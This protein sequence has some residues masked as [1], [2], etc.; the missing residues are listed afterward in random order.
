MLTTDYSSVICDMAAVGL[1]W[2]RAFGLYDGDN[3][4]GEWDD[5]KRRWI[6]VENAGNVSPMWMAVR[7]Y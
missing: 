3:S 6:E 7:K 4:N 1:G 2:E 5:A